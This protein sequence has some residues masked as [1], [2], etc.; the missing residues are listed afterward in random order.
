MSKKYRLI[1]V[2]DSIDSG[3]VTLS[4]MD[5]SPNYLHIH[6]LESERLGS[7]ENF[8]QES[9]GQNIDNFL[10]QW[11]IMF[12]KDAKI[13]SAKV[14]AEE[15]KK[16]GQVG[17][18]SAACGEV[19][20]K[21]RDRDGNLIEKDFIGGGEAFLSN[22]QNFRITKGGGVFEVADQEKYWSFQVADFSN[23]QRISE[24][25]ENQI[26]GR[27]KLL[28]ILKEKSGGKPFIATF[29]AEFVGNFLAR[30][31]GIFPEDKAAVQ[32]PEQSLFS[33]NI[34]GGH[35]V[36]GSRNVGDI[37]SL[38]NSG[39]S[40][41]ADF[42]LKIVSD[43]FLKPIDQLQIAKKDGGFREPRTQFQV[44]Q[45]ALLIQK[46]FRKKFRGDHEK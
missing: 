45:A 43:V 20:S 28:E 21:K 4:T 29:D 26:D 9:S 11:G 39:F 36:G 8:S 23:A 31:N 7:I 24:L 16:F 15:V 12:E 44:N 19:E 5:A 46:E 25:K 3:E 2:L 33:E 41:E 34:K 22:G 13:R 35:L 40:Q 17:I 27:E 14:T 1:C 42:S 37:E 38:R 18:G 10:Y 32:N 6:V 30:S